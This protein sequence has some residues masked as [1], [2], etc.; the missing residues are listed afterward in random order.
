MDEDP[1]ASGKEAP[2]GEQ[3]APQDPN[4]QKDTVRLRL[5][6]PF[7]TWSYVREDADGGT[8]VVDRDG[9]D[10]PAA[11]ADEI[12]QT[13]ALLGVTLTREAQA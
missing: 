10:V 2:K 6:H 9:T 1:Q 3:A 4:A 7:Y 13:A 8:L 5:T 12:I 11:D